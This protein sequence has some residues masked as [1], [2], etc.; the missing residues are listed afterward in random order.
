MIF[1][2]LFKSRRSSKAALCVLSLPIAFFL[3]IFAFESSS[4]A[5]NVSGSLWTD[6]PEAS[7]VSTGRRLIFPDV[8]RTLRIDHAVLHNLIAIAPEEFSP[9]VSG[10]GNII[11]LPMPDGSFQRFRFYDSPIMEPDLAAKFPEIRT[12]SGQGIDEPAAIVRFDVTQFGFHALVLRPEGSV[13]IDP[14]ALGDKD[15]YIS[16]FKRDFSA[17]EKRFVCETQSDDLIRS[18]RPRGPMSVFGEDENVVNNGGTLHKYRLAMAATGEYTAFYGGTVAGAMSGITTTVNRVNAV[19][20]RD[21]SVRLILIANNNL[22]VYTNAATDPYTNTS[23]DLNAN[24]SNINSVIGSANYDVGHLVGTGG[25]GVAQLRVPCTSSKAKGLTGSPSPIGDPFDIDYVSHEM[26]HQFGGNHTFNSTRSSC[27]GGNRNAATAFEPGSAS[28]IQGYAGICGTSDLQRNSD[29][30]FHII[31]LEEMTAFI[32]G[33]GESCDVDTSTGNS[34]PTVTVPADFTAPMQTP[35]VLTG[36][37]SDANGDTLTY[38]WEEYDTGSSTNA[39]PNSDSGGPLPIF[40][41]YKPATSPTRYFPSLPFILN[42]AN[43]PPATFSGTNAVGTYCSSG[44]CLTGELMSQRDRTM[45][46]QMTVRDNRSGG[47]AVRSAQTNVTITTAAGPFKVTSPNSGVTWYSGT[48]QTITWNVANTT[49]APVSCP[50]VD[51]LLS[52]NG[53]LSFPLLVLAATP[54]DGTQNAYIPP[55]AGTTSR[56][57]IQCSTAPWFDIS[58]V[59]FT[60]L[61]PSAGGVTVEGRVTDASG[62][63]V[64]RM[65]VVFTDQ[66]GIA[67]TTVTSS[68][69]YFRFDDLPAGVTYAVSGASKLFTLVPQVIQVQDQMT[70]VELTA[71]S[72]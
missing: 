41:S 32:T 28:T 45:K 23:S 6:V 4:A 9:E 35:F 44:N 42:N 37:G 43:V 67:Y 30:Y 71:A 1:A 63:G 5:Q 51:I 8:Y 24:Q 68:F 54:N 21:L 56:I 15:N 17:P 22:I 7:L 19:Y 31:S 47:G 70:N 58:D 25:G 62:R 40:R 12:F 53:G 50:N 34:I 72:N 38:T 39:I 59:N 27:G 60:L 26:G 36:S 52:T 10:A 11:T 69:G 33:T 2:N 55:S 16:Y 46:F 57:K 61:A 64:S 49:D 66:H 65:A 20:E 13:Y 29:D 3:L 48:N 18:L 14:Y